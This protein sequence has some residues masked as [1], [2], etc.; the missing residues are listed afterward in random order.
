VWALAI[1]Q[2]VDTTRV[3]QNLTQQKIS[4]SYSQLS[5]IYSFFFATA[6]FTTKVS[7]LLFYRRIFTCSGISFRIAFWFCT[8]LVVSY[9]I[10]FTLT[11]S[12]ACQPL[13]HFWTQFK[14]TEGT[15]IDVGKFYVILAI[16]SLA[17]NFIMIFI[18]V[19]EVM[20][21]QMSRGKKAAVFGILALGGL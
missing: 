4:C 2:L 17:T 16:V 8:L 10:I 20:K 11:M 6:V 15:C 12:F 7:I 21:L 19:P 3:S 18:P 1:D 9:P 5:Y 13:S 14:G